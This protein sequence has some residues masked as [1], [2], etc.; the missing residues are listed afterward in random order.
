MSK[1]MRLLV[2]FDLPVVTNREKREYRRFR[3]FL[4]NEGYDMLQF[5]VY[6]RVCH[7]HEATDKHL[8]RLKR[9]L[10]PRGSIRAMVVTEKQYAKMQLLLGEPTAQE[11]KVTS[12]QLTLF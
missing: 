5:S 6:S 8:A 12:T 10:P 7:G 1:F 4:L 9:N 2:F 3:T 11:K